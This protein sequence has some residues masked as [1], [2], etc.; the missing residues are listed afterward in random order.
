[1]LKS[2]IVKQFLT[3]YPETP[4][5]TL[6]IIIYRENPKLFKDVE[7]ARTMIR[8]YRGNHGNKNRN[9]VA[10]KS[11]YRDNK[12]NG[13]PFLKLPEGIKSLNWNVFKIIGT[14]RILNLSDIHIP[15]HDKIAVELAIKRGLEFKPTI[16]LLN[17]DILDFFSLSRWETNP[18]E[19]DFPYEIEVAKLFFAYLREN[20]PKVRIIWKLGNH[21]ERLDS[22]MFVKSP[23]LLGVKTF[24][25]D[26]I[27]D[28]KKYRIEIV[29]DKRPIKINKLSVIHGH[30][31]R[32]AISNPVNPARGLF[33]RA[34]ANAMCSHFHQSS[35]HSARNIDDK[36]ISTWSL[37]CLSE[38]HPRFLPL[39]EWNHGFALIETDGNESFL[40]SNY[41]IIDGKTY[42]A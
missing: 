1:M 39:N 21:E 19:R 26:N 12:P 8:H 18:K 17:G 30:E 4:S 22:Y 7:N 23:E 36:M 5:K 9:K 6:A 20:F 15:Y 28:L 42:T 40:V 31:Y 3:E 34:K 29:K 37:G 16:V 35:A 25:I 2:D 41:K 14:N 13:N 32:F 27:Y 24:E 10:D 33:L 11:F 38:L